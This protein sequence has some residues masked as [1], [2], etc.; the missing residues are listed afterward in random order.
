MLRLKQLISCVIV[1]QNLDHQ[2]YY[3]F[4]YPT[5]A[6]MINKYFEILFL[7]KG[8]LV[9]IVVQTEAIQE[10]ITSMNYPPLDTIFLQFIYL[11]VTQLK[12][13]VCQ[14]TYY[15]LMYFKLIKQELVLSHYIP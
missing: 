3:R 2:V 4:L 13:E 5:E 10:F 9:A 1:I 6:Q 7:T 12:S 11:V 14:E 15:V 8:Q